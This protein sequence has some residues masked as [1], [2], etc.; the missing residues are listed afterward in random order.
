MMAKHGHAQPWKDAGRDIAVSC[1]TCPQTAVKSPSDASGVCCI[2]AAQAPT[3][4]V[5]SGVPCVNCG[6]LG[7]SIVHLDR[8]GTAAPWE[9]RHNAG[10]KNNGYTQ[11]VSL[12][13]NQPS[14][15]F[16]VATKDVDVTF[17]TRTQNASS[18]EET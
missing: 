12:H 7:Q 9:A 1:A 5:R 15:N 18:F 14:V 8:T 10:S 17:E 4:T 16:T 6:I 11:F 2:P 13:A 3:V